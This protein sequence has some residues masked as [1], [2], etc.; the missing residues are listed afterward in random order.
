MAIEESRLK[1]WLY[2]ILSALFVVVLVTT[3]TFFLMHLVDG[4]PYTALIENA[5]LEEREQYL[6]KNGLHRP[7]CYQYYHFIKKLIFH[8]DFGTS[9]VNRT[10]TVSDIL[11][12]SL[13]TSVLLGG[14]SVFIAVTIGFILGALSSYYNHQLYK[15]L[16]SV[17]CM[18][19]ISLPVFVWAPCLQSFLGTRLGWLPV[20]GWGSIEHIILPVI[21]LLPN[22]MASTMK[23]TQN[24]IEKIR[25]SDYYINIRQRGMNEWQIFRKHIIRNAMPPI[26]TVLVSNLS[27]IFSGAFI[28]EKIFSVPGIGRELSLIHI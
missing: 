27:G 17:L 5:S 13:F 24:S 28:V 8:L 6:N 22:T 16:T 2:K 11:K 9:L 12:S 25:K 18:V 4:D 26:I 1:N 10:T 20:S 14:I 23:F 7:L 19:G 21:C 15:T 3:I